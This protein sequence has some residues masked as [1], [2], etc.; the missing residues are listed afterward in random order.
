[1]HSQ[2]TDEFYSDAEDIS[3]EEIDDSN[4]PQ[5]KAPASEEP[6]H[7]ERK[8]TRWAD[9]DAGSDLETQP[10][11]SSS[12]PTAYRAI[13]PVEVR[14]GGRSSRGRGRGYSSSEPDWRARGRSSPSSAAA[15]DGRWSHSRPPYTSTP[16]PPTAPKIYKRDTGPS[17]RP[18]PPAVAHHHFSP[19]DSM[20]PAVRTTSTAGNS[21]GAHRGPIGGNGYHPSPTA[22]VYPPPPPRTVAGTYS[23]NSGGNFAVNVA[24]IDDGPPPGFDILDEDD[25]GPPPGF[26]GHTPSSFDGVDV[27]TYEDAPPPGFENIVQSGQNAGAAVPTRGGR[28]DFREYRG[29]RSSW[30][31][32]RGR[33]GGRNTP[34]RGVP[35]RGQSSV[36]RGRGGGRGRGPPSFAMASSPPPPPPPPPPRSSGPKEQPGG[37]AA[38]VPPPPPLPLPMVVDDTSAALRQLAL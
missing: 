18:P 3:G 17:V 6:A 30:A 24:I 5:T 8:S 7:V 38:G 15:N 31:P 20:S 16:P 26:E 1:M 23:L 10:L 25:D 35:A 34:G 28:G 37:P 12:P 4:H 32:S 36:G 33:T 21:F 29:G 13:P 11:P 27:S 19:A 9:A 14:E 22:P 2:S